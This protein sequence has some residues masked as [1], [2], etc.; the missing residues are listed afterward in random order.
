MKKKFSQRAPASDRADIDEKP[1]PIRFEL[2]STL[3]SLQIKKLPLSDNL[4]EDVKWELSEV[5]QNAELDRFKSAS[6]I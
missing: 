1:E 3:L 2:H 6:P 5:R 4:S